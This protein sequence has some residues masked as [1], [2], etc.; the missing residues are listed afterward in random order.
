M[1]ANRR[2]F[3]VGTRAEVRDA[4]AALLGGPGATLPLA[5]ASAGDVVVV[6]VLAAGEAAAALPT[7]HVFGGVRALKDRQGLAVFVVVGA[8][9]AV[10][11]QLARF[12]LADGVLRWD[13]SRQHLDGA[14]LEAAA[15]GPRRVPVDALLAK[16]EPRLTADGA[17][18]HLQRLLRFERDDSPLQR[19]QDEETGLFDG[20]FAT[21]KLDEEWKRAHRFHQPLSLLLLDLGSAVERLADADRRQV[22][23][24][25]AGVF[26]NECRDIDVLARFAP[27]VFLF[28]LPGTGAA[29]AEVLARRIT[30]S[31]QRRFAGRHGVQPC[32]GVATAPASDVPDRRTFL[33]VAE[34]CL[35]AARAR[36]PGQV[37][38]TWQ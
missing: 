12:A 21:W 32:C 9:D 1:A 27:T 16:L 13:Q 28:L 14:E 7:G 19:L 29:G 15:I 23:A 22:L 35:V 25:A 17:E 4:A 11:V 31:L 38:A 5:A 36:G 6:D 30:G 18:S 37:A 2:W 26:L 8:D 24:E 33:A 20:P 3:W 10:G 34:A